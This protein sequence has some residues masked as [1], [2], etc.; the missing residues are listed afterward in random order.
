MA[1]A[2]SAGLAAFLF[3]GSVARAWICS[4]EGKGSSAKLA[5]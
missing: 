5:R 3:V 4:V 1:N 2:M